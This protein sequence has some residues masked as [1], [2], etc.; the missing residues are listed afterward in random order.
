LILVDLPGYGFAKAAQTERKRWAEFINLYLQADEGLCEAIVL[1]D[2]RNGPTSLDDEAIGFLLHEQVAVRIFM[3]KIDQLKTQSERE[4]RKKEVTA[5][6]AR[7][8]I[9]PELIH[10]VSAEKKDGV[11]AL[12]AVLSEVARSA[13]KVISE[14]IQASKNEEE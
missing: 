4:R 3:T 9:G 12:G 11:N 10:W 5:S 6:L 1:L 2:S 7:W 14:R 13:S 8:G